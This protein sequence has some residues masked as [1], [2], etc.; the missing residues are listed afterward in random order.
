[1]RK[2]Y[3]SPQTEAIE[4]VVAVTLCASGNKATLGSG[5]SAS[6]TGGL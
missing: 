1:M 6:G 5:S 3:S 2:I 4:I